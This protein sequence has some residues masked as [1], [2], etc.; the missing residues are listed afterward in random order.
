MKYQTP[1]L[2]TAL[3]PFFA[4]NSA[5]ASQGTI[6]FNGLVT[7]STC[8]VSVDGQGD[9]STITLPTVDAKTLANAADTAGRTAFSI[10][11]SDCTMSTSPADT[12]VSTFFEAGPT[13][14]LATG[15]LN[16]SGV[17]TNVQLQILDG[18]STAINVGDSSQI[19]DNDYQTIAGTSGTGTATLN[20]GVEYYATGQSTAGT[21]ISS[22][23]YSMQYK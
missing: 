11:L 7:A 16:S 14:D 3:L 4:L 13:V 8:T 15:R 21:V 10:E 5:Q 23:V 19:A 1:L 20:Y 2:V 18:D 17:A 22:V 6:T 12:Q 9:D